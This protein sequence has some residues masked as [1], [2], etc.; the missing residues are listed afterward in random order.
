MFQHHG[1]IF[2]LLASS[3]A[4]CVANECEKEDD[5][6]SK[7]QFTFR[8]DWVV[9]G[10]GGN[11][12]VT[13]SLDE[14]LKN[15]LPNEHIK[16]T[17]NGTTFETTPNSTSIGKIWHVYTSTYS[18]STTTKPTNPELILA[19]NLLLALKNLVDCDTGG[20]VLMNGTEYKLAPSDKVKALYR[21]EPIII[22]EISLRIF[23]NQPGSAD[24]SCQE[25]CS[26]INSVEPVGQAIDLAAIYKKICAIV[27]KIA[28]MLEPQKWLALLV[29]VWLIV[30]L[31]IAMLI[32]RQD[33]RK[34]RL[35]LQERAEYSFSK[36]RDRP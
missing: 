16:I 11:R 36:P 24:M 14:H 27:V 5:G 21:Y 35:H 23:K 33:R 13:T 3:I 29:S 17:P 32:K 22:S 2:F 28:S 15:L 26:Q 18:L 7:Q 25:L 10:L 20:C 19:D 6:A 31:V 9:P 4:C 12:N 8:F 1:V 30:C 34:L